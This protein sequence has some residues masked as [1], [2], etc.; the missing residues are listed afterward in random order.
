MVRVG[1]MTNNI[2]PKD[3]DLSKCPE[4]CFMVAES[5]VTNSQYIAMLKI[6]GIQNCMKC[7]GG[8]P[9]SLRRNK[10]GNHI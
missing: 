4:C 1:F 9:E 6:H 7:S 5:D 3:Y 10:Y 2:Y 8:C